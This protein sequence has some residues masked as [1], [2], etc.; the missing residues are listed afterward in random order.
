MTTVSNN[1]SKTT[2][3]CTLC[4]IIGLFQGCATG[5]SQMEAETFKFKAKYAGSL[6]VQVGDG[7]YE[8][9]AVMEVSDEGLREAIE[10]SA[11]KSGLFNPVS[12]APANTDYLL[13]AALVKKQQPLV[14]LSS[15]TQTEI[16]WRLIDQRNNRVVWSQSIT[17]DASGGLAG[18]AGNNRTAGAANAIR[19]NIQQALTEISE[20]GL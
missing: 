9:A 8:G 18:I 3:L 16:Y 1:R 5:S 2:L 11:R 20:L 17:T 12:T 4:L 15:Q 19:A 6:A 7:D 10:A 13:Y 14:S